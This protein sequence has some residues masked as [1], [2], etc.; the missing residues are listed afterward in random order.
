MNPWYII[1]SI[2]ALVL[3]LWFFYAVL[4]SRALTAAICAYAQLD[5]EQKGRFVIR[6]DGLFPWIGPHPPPHLRHKA[7]YGLI[8]YQHPELG[9]CL[10]ETC[11]IDLDLDDL[12][13]AD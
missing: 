7:R 2:V 8:A 1:G 11:R 10:V 6:V 3:V 13:P 5:P 9:M 4:Y 12:G